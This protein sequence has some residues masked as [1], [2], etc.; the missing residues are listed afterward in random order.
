MS[1][2]KRAFGWESEEEGMFPGIY[3][4]RSQNDTSAMVS[5][6]SQVIS[7]G[8]T[9]NHQ[10]MINNSPPDQ[11]QSQDHQPNSGTYIHTH[12]DIYPLN[13]YV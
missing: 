8:A 2:G 6:L 5:A 13:L 7:G 10:H 12:T 9:P 1:N 11:S 4:A 3:S